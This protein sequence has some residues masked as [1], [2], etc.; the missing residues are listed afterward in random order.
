MN[1]NDEVDKT[2]WE[3]KLNEAVKKMTTVEPTLKE[4]YEAE[5]D[6]ATSQAKLNAELMER[7]D[8]LEKS[9]KKPEK[10][11]KTPIADGEKEEMKELRKA[12]LAKFEKKPYGG[13]DLETLK[14]KLE[15]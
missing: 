13:W 8:S 2:P 10:Q 15:E 12:Y 11:S 6:K 1:N 5:K 3:K 7:L 4:K 9:L 14:T